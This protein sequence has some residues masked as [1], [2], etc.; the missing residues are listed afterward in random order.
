[1]ENSGLDPSHDLHRRRLLKGALAAGLLPHGHLSF[2]QQQQQWQKTIPST[3]EAIPPVGMG[4][5][6]TFNV[7]KDAAIRD[8]RADVLAAFFA[9]GGGMIDSS[10]MYGSA[11][12]VLGALLPR[13]SAETKDKLFSATKVWT[14][15]DGQSQ[16]EQSHQLW[17]IPKFD[18][19]QVHNLRNWADHL[20]VLQKMKAEEQLRY[21]GV[22]TSHGRRHADFEAV[23]N[24]EAIDFVQLTYNPLDREVESRLLPLA[25]DKGLAVIVNRPF[26]RGALIDRVAG[27]PLPSVAADLQCKS[28]AQLLLK[29]VLSHP[30][31]T[32]VIPA[33][34]QVAHMQENMA[35][36]Y[37]QMPTAA[38][39]AK[40]VNAVERA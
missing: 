2:A 12:E 6:V 4:T 17:Q 40:I 32:C 21:V 13:F 1:M 34:S 15:G 19:F 36:A 35:A 37:G 25:Q 20:P 30:A 22:S 38:Q 29:Y 28:W 39:R 11:E 14:S 10:P 7:G 9:A 16:I 3:N 31:V 23:M 8:E 5:W 33:T 27:T 26:Q 18:L 24:S